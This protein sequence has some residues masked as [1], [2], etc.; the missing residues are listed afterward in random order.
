MQ[1]RADKNIPINQYLKKVCI[2]YENSELQVNQTKSLIQSNFFQEMEQ[3]D[4]E[5]WEWRC[6]V[7]NTTLIFSTAFQ[8]NFL[9][10]IYEFPRC[11]V[12]FECD[13]SIVSDVELA[14]LKI[15]KTYIFIVWQRVFLG[16]H[17]TCWLVNIFRHLRWQLALN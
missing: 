3:Q 6:R 10:Q 4:I 17:I 14:K 15:T 9:E 7:G 11:S 13:S 16:Y 12:I 2:L 8:N 5:R 1:K